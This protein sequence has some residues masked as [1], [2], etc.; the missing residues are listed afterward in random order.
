MNED[1]L[2]KLLKEEIKESVAF[3]IGEEIAAGWFNTGKEGGGAR[4]DTYGVVQVVV[5]KGDV[6]D[7]LQKIIN[8][9]AKKQ[10]INLLLRELQ[11]KKISAESE[12]N[13]RYIT[14]IMEKALSD[15]QKLIVRTEP[16][17]ND[18][19]IRKFGNSE[20]RRMILKWID[21]E[22]YMK[23]PSEKEKMLIEAT[24]NSKLK[25]ENLMQYHSTLEHKKGIGYFAEYIDGRTIRH[26]IQDSEILKKH[27]LPG[28]KE[29]YAIGYYLCNGLAHMH[30]NKIVH[31]DIKKDN[32]M[33]TLKEGILKII[34]FG[35]AKECTFG[36][37]NFLDKIEFD[38]TY[39]APEMIEQTTVKI[40]N[41]SGSSVV[42]LPNAKI[43]YGP[44]T[45][46]WAVGVTL[47]EIATFSHP[48]GVADIS[49]YEH[50]FKKDVMRAKPTHI[51]NYN[52]DFNYFDDLILR[53]LTND[54]KKRPSAAEMRELFFKEL[55]KMG[56]SSNA[57]VQEI[58]REY[59]K[60]IYEKREKEYE[61]KKVEDVKLDVLPR[62]ISGSL[63]EA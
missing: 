17:Y 37:K 6:K 7:M 52:K 22:D 31:K 40:D 23:D 44:E 8:Y 19:K 11:V 58:L 36:E 24:I 20:L 51:C 50:R 27:K 60:P 32:I 3:S 46:M 63:V 21:R 30:E 41:V 47:Y 13:Y 14:P 54:P 61:T 29:V 35:L 10:D 15:L 2:R 43:P 53:L 39:A 4:G 9:T 38:I 62:A 45:D 57:E 49:N 34:D 33:L 26:V 16:A 1:E 55:Q 42:S 48:F 5:D 12:R 28:K 56:Y 18:E 59:I 25:N